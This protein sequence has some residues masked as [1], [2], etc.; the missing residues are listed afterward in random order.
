MQEIFDY[1]P[2]INFNSFTNEQDGTLAFKA[3]N[4]NV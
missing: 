1:T 4:D 2:C 3:N